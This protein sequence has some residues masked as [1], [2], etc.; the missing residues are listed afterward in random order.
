MSTT[1]TEALIQL[2][3][4]LV[5]IPG[6]SLQEQNVALFIRECLADLPFRVEMDDAG[7]TLGGNTGN[8]IVKPHHLDVTKPV[9]VYMAH[10][11]T[12]RDTSGIGIIRQDGR[13]TSDGTSQLGADNRA[14]VAVLMHLLLNHSRW[15]DHNL[16]YLVVFSVAEEIGLKGAELMDLSGYDVEGVFVFDSSKR[17]GAYIRDCAGKFR[18]E[19]EIMGRAAHSAVAPEEGISAIMVAA[20]ALRDVRI[21]RLNEMTTINIGRI[22]GGEANNI[23]APSCLVTGEV[24]SETMQEVAAHLDSIE[25]SFQKAASRA[26]ATLTFTRTKDF[27][28]YALPEGSI[29]VLAVEEAIRRAGLTVQ[30]LRY[31]G[32]S[33]ANVMN[34]KGFKAVNIGI[35][36]QKPHADDEFI[37]EEDLTAAYVIAEHLMDLHSK[38]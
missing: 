6:I 9:R 5:R 20:E 37:L 15:Q 14:G 19:A 24:R 38:M 22:T 13:I 16:N 29:V 31:S 35:G 1:S 7:A 12:V 17:P 26:G 4:E 33:D 21:G 23:V 34:E 25:A 8:L 32:G 3:T 10:M 2:F 30:P 18:F 11:D 27:A 28:P 36:A